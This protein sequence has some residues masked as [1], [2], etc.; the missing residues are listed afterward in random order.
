MLGELPPPPPRI[1]FGRDELIEKVVHLAESLK[2]IALIG[3]GGIGK[4]SI[5]LTALHDK[6]IEERFG[7][8]RRFIRCDEFPATRNHFLRHLSKVI[9]AGI[10]NPETLAA[11][12]PFLSSKELLIV[13]DNAE[14]ILDPQGPSAQ[15]IHADVDE[16][17]QIGNICIWITSRISTIPP[18]CE[19]IEIPTLPTAAAHDTFYRIYK[20]GE[21]WDSINDILEQLE[22]HPLSITLLAIVAQQSKWSVD[23][24]IVEWE[25][26][27]TRV[28]RVQHSKSL[29]TTIELSLN[30][31]MFRELGPHARSLLEIVAFFTQGVNEK[32]SNWLFPTIPDVQNM[33]DGFCMLSLAYRNNGF[34][35]M[36]APLRDHLRPKDP[37]SSQLLN[38][39]KECYFGR[40]S[41]DIPPGQ[42]GFEEARWIT[43]EDINVE[44]LLDVFTTANPKSESIWNVCAE[45]MAQ[46]YFHKSRLV[47]LGPKIEALPDNHPSKALCLLRLS[48][49][50]DSV[51][52]SMERKRLLSHSLKLWREWRDDFRVAQTLRHLSDA[53]RRMGLFTEG[54]PQAKEASE[55]FE[56]LGE[57]VQRANSLIK[58]ASLLRSGGQLDAAEEAGSRALDLLPEK[59]EEVW[60]CQGHRT[61]G[62]IYLSKS[63][64]KKAIHHFEKALEIASSLNMA[65]QLVWIN[66]YLAEVF[67]KQGEFEDAQTHLERAK[68]HAGD[69]SYLLAYVMDQQARVWDEQGRLEEA[70][71]EALRALDAFEKLGA[72]NDAEDVRGLLRYI[73]ARRAG[74]PG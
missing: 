45:F 26:Q 73:D 51:G 12:R 54:I 55:I 57:V 22:F 38:A 34:V 36:L 43:T 11:L 41:G 48:R 25:R 46:L 15:E 35:T 61:L 74:Q 9:G 67:S 64:A 69:E 44:H 71:S 66:Y 29:A 40:L 50:F 21:R 31:P 10:E 27:R 70:R 39:T 3:A 1:F 59:G 63:E 60:V 4:T 14:S 17:T 53:N 30:S 58:L 19:T 37:S 32:N 8:D 56:R 68:S 62:Q 20:H 18:D 28:L 49:L 6:R 42:P 52:N 2:L 47:T 24:L 16:L 13:L 5:I 33:L 23:R 7:K 72:A 65:D